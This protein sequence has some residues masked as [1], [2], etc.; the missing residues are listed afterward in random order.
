MIPRMEPSDVLRLSIDGFKA[1][2]GER[3]CELLDYEAGR[4]ATI[5]LPSREVLVIS[6]GTSTMKVF[7]CTKRL[8][9]SRLRAVLFGWV[10]PKTVLSA[11]LARFGCGCKQRSGIA[12]ATSSVL[13]L[14]AT[15]EMLTL[16]AVN[17]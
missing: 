14:A 1:L 17:P 2:M 7:D 9:W 13:L 8:G 16:H 5:R 12:R 6:I 10:R 15:V 3:R 11:D 4:L